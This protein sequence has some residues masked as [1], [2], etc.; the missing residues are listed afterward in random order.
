VVRAGAVIA[1]AGV[2]LSLMVGVSRTLFSMSAR[3]DM[4]GLLAHVN[5]RYRVPDRAELAVAAFVIAVVALADVRGAIGF[6]SFGVLLYYAIA[7]ASA[8][9]LPGEDLRW[10]RALTVLGVAGCLLL[11][12][13][14]PWE[15]VLAGAAVVAA[16]AIVF[17]LRRIIPKQ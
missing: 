9:T 7:N 17:G 13:S 3:G 16:G 11:A 8:F 6:S 1:S 10:P 12:F 15:S 2:L 14:L 4:P 5:P